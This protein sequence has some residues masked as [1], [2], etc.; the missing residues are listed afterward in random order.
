MTEQEIFSKKA[1]TSYTVCIAEH[2][3]KKERCLRWKVGQH[4]TSQL[5]DFHCVNLLYKDVATEN[6]PRFRSAEKV[7]FAKGMTG[8]F[9]DD[10]PRR[11]EK[12]VRGELMDRYC[13]SY[14]FE[15]R[16]GSRL[17]P[18]AMQ[19]EIRGLFQEAG[20]NGEVKFDGYVEDYN[21]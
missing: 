19:E 5:M 3:P 17:I 20:W 6:C 21:W 12:Y 1:E 10:M 14:F 8:I 15:F 7:Q 18:P 4:M 11:V 9:T 13:R 16:N 2:C